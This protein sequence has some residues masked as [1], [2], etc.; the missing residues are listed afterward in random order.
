VTWD[1]WLF[2]DEALAREALRGWVERLWRVVVVGFGASVLLSRDERDERDE[3]EGLGSFDDV[4]DDG[5]RASEGV[6][7]KGVSDFFLFLEGFS[8]AVSTSS[9]IADPD[10]FRVRL[11]DE[12]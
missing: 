7:A 9:S 1:R 3:D 6:G 5:W 10:T 11:L 2:E 4:E 12:G 8:C